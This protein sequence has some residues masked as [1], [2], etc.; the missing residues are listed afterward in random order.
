MEFAP[1]AAADVDGRKTMA[2]IRVAVMQIGYDDGQVWHPAPART[3]E[4]NLELADGYLVRAADAR[5]DIA[6][7]PECW[8]KVGLERKRA[9]DVAE[10]VPGEGPVCTMCRRRAREHGMHVVGWTY[11]RDGEHIYNTSFILSP[12]GDLVG[13]YRKTHPVPGETG[14]T[15]VPGETHGETEVTAGEELPVFD[16]PFGRV[17]IMICFDNWHAEVPRILAV[18]GARLIIYPTM[19]S[20]RDVFA[21]L[22]AARAIDSGVFVAASVVLGCRVS[23]GCAAIYD[24]RGEVVAGT[25]RRDGVAV[26]EIDLDKSYPFTFNPDQTANR[27]LEDS[28]AWLLSTRRPHLYGD[29]SDDA[30][31]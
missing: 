13:K 21:T 17:G 28:R 23:G 16:L 30:V 12:G 15:P 10:E 14:E 25:G 9:S 4:Q 22:A 8:S 29:L 1:P 20:P 31:I 19:N 11:E 26:G 5:T 24:P 2:P 27:R 7:L 18:K 6:I 3:F